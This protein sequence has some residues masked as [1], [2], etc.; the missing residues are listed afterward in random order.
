MS[1]P[2]DVLARIYHGNFCRLAG[3]EPCALNLD[4]ALEECDR[5]V[6][7][8]SAFSGTPAAETEAARVAKSL[9]SG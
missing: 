6:A 1:L 9:R 3:D 2:D 5:V 4:R 7:I 8:A